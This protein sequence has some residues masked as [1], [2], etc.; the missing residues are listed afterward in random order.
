MNNNWLKVPIGWII[1]PYT[2]D[3]YRMWAVVNASSVSRGRGYYSDYNV[4]PVV[5]L[6]TNIILKSG[7]GTEADH[8]ELG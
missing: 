7:T 4:R 2:S 6:K 1:T 8:Y 5:T 3:N